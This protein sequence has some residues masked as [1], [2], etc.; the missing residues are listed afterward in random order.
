MSKT[1]ERIR[2]SNLRYKQSLGQNFLY[3]EGLLAEL[4]AAAGV[5]KDEDVLEIGPG[6]GSLT[7]HL[8]D[9]A[10]RVLAVELDER[11]IPLLHAFLDEKK[12]LTV[13]QGD[14]MSLNLQEVTAELKKPFAVVANIPY[15]ITTPLIKLLLGGDLPV[16][17]LALMVQQEVADKI[18]A[19]PGEDAWGPLSIL[20]QFLCEPRLAVKVPAEMFTPP[21]KVDSAFVVLPVREKPAV[22]VKDRDL[23]FRVANAAFA[24]RR[25]TMVNNLCA[26]FRV[27]RAKAVE[28][29][30]GAGLDEKIRGEKLTLE[31]LASLA[32]VIE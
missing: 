21:P 16:S 19:Q 1:K 15:Y 7:K 6:C 29:V 4:T 8:C 17:R 22:E 31:E 11:L 2:E 25:K 13:V 20:C 26:T 23:F 18:L 3:D 14:V 10:N 9:A 32:N 28:W 27:D 30:T 24:L 12:N 5:T